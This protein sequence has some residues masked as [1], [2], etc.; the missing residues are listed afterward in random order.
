MK[1]E[2]GRARPAQTEERRAMRTFLALAVVALSVPAL[3]VAAGQSM[4]PVVSAKLK[5]SSE[6]P[7][8]GDPNGKGLAV[9][10]FDTTKGTTCWS[11]KG[12]SGI[13]KPTAAHI[14]KGGKGASGPV[15]VPF[16][17]TY[18]ASG[19]VKTPTGTIEKIE[20]NPNAY[21][22]NIHNTKYPAGALRGQLV[23]GMAG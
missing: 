17:S 9:I 22:V 7:V 1:A 4:S 19:C 11:F 2:A 13:A 23:T 10:H 18:K 12:V 15:V 8:K 14:H 20:T 5:G 16:G 21:Y 6:A 3:A